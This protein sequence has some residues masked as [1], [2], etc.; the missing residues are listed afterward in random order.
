M[1]DYSLW[2]VLAGVLLISELTTGTF[3]LMLVAVGALLGSAAA[4]LG[5]SFPIQLTVSAVFALLATWALKSSRAGQPAAADHSQLDLGNTVVV[6]AWN[7]QGHTKVNYRGAQWSAQ[8]LDAQA[9]PGVHV[10]ES[11]DLNVLKLKRQAQA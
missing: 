10:I 4:Y 5:Y 2:L 9:Q 8:S 11:I 1:T 6:E 7:E 3:Y